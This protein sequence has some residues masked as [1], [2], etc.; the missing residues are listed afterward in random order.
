MQSVLDSPHNLSA[1]GPGSIRAASEDQVC[2]FCHTPHNATPIRPLWNR[3]IPT[4]SY[5]VYTSKALDAHPGQ[6]TGSSKLCLSCHDGTIALGSVVSRDQIIQMAGGITTIPPGRSSNLGT[7]L[8]DDHPISFRY[9]S[10]LW[11]KDP[12]LVDPHALPS[13]LHLDPNQELQCTTCHDAHD[14]VYGDFLVMNNLNSAL[15]T[16]CHN[17]STTTLPSHM[18]CAS[19]HQPHTAPSGPYLLRSATISG[20]CTSCHDGTHS[21]AANIL[22]ELSR[23]SVHDTGS[24][25]DPPEPIAGHATCTD[26]HE[27][28]SMSSGTAR[29]P[30]IS[31]ALGR[32]SGVNSSGAAVR[33][34]QHEYEVCY[35]CHA[36]QSST[37]L[38]PIKRQIVQYNKRFQFDAAAISSHPIEVAGR[39]FDVPSLRAGW[40]TSSMMSCSDCHNSDT[41]RKAG[42]MGPNGVHGSNE[43]PLLIARYVTADYTV[44]SVGTYALCYRCHERSN[45]NG[46]ILDDASF[47]FH[48]LHIVAQQ[49]PCSA[50]HDAHGVSSL[51]GSR[52]HNSNL[53]NFDTSIVFPEAGSGIL[54]FTDTGIYRGSCTLT[55]H[56]KA[57]VNAEY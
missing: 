3:A 31:P 27:P 23:L 2:I 17:I 33:V 36:G 48:N 15:C 10:S 28:H 14:N 24:P 49:T 7:D 47:R 13:A 55:C 22:A 34:A 37:R 19:C 53:I 56:G 1:S 50:C 39:N 42:G 30:G 4:S 45:G 8:S 5:T 25:V 38:F 16:S 43:Q 57:H 52:R 12:N 35:K 21:G 18:G 41:S 51:Q 26:C 20:T 46:G 11:R 44:E 54:R 40:T 32:V 29:A 9:D 6:P